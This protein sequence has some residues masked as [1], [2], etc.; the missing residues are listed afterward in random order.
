MTSSNIIALIGLMGAGKSAIGQMLARALNYDFIDAD[1][2]IEEESGLIIADIFELYGE[3]KFREVEQ[4]VI[5]EIV[6]KTYG[7]GVILS[8]GGGAFCQPETQKIMLEHTKTLWLRARP[9]TL[10]GRIKNLST[11]PLL[12]GPDPLGVLRA[13]NEKR[14]VFYEKADIIVDT[15]GSTKEQS[16]AALL[17]AL[18]HN[19]QMMSESQAR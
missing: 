1:K 15:D 14:A 16:L 4:R 7:G 17:Q 19:Q 12:S 5:S 2:R 18:E 9:E 10:L 8:T 11:R 13:L 6:S 3:A